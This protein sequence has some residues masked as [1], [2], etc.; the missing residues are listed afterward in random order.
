[1][2]TAAIVIDSE[3]DAGSLVVSQGSPIPFVLNFLGDHSLNTLSKTFRGFLKQLANGA[4][5]SGGR[6]G[7]AIRPR[8]VVQSPRVW[9][10]WLNALVTE[11]NVTFGRDDGQATPEERNFRRFQTGSQFAITDPNLTRTYGGMKFG[12]ISSSRGRNFA[13]AFCGMNLRESGR[14]E[15]IGFR[16]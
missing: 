7:A 3:A 15:E 11:W 14:L 6:G 4:S 12:A 2:N 16:F 13:R 10:T 9:P 5:S 1:M 8:P